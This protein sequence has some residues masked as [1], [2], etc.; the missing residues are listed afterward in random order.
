VILVAT[1][2]NVY[3][4]LL[5]INQQPLSAAESFYNTTAICRLSTR[6]RGP[7]W[8]TRY[9]A[10]V[11]RSV[12]PVTEV[13]ATQPECINHYQL[14]WWAG[15]SQSTRQKHVPA[16][17]FTRCHGSN[18]WNWLRTLSPWLPRLHTTVT[19]SSLSE[20]LMQTKSNPTC[21]C[22]RL[23]V[24]CCIEMDAYVVAKCTA[25]WLRISD[26]SHSKTTV[27]DALSYSALPVQYSPILRARW[28][29]AFVIGHRH[30]STE[31]EN[32][33]AKALRN[34]PEV[35]NNSREDL[36]VRSAIVYVTVNRQVAE[37]DSTQNSERRS[38]FDHNESAEELRTMPNYEDQRTVNASNSELIGLFDVAGGYA[39]A[40]DLTLW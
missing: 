11:G 14:A 8:H 21:I 4:D 31:C 10:P 28:S 19:E 17:S 27:V 9:S 36:I 13:I 18:R 40:P 29:L 30:G 35:D 12:N 23:L 34:R 24:F 3:V 25:I 16:R 37:V 7:R 33:G 26:L 39:N 32:I 15:S 38:R 2:E 6:S 1:E 5:C 20:A 22:D